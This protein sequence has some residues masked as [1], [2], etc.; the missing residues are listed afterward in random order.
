MTNYYAQ[1]SLVFPLCV[2]KFWPMLSEMFD[3]HFSSKF[4]PRELTF[5]TL[6]LCEQ[7]LQCQFHALLFIYMV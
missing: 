7:K 5:L 2:T 4:L 3:W 1:N 6:S